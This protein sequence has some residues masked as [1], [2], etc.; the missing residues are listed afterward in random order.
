MK[1]QNLLKSAIIALV[2]I[3]I[4]IGGLI[5]MLQF[6]GSDEPDIK[7]GA[8]SMSAMAFAADVLKDNDIFKLITNR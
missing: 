7:L 3:T 4:L 5:L 8:L 1:K 2:L 6:F